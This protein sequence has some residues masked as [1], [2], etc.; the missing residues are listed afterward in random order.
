MLVG[1]IK[2]VNGVEQV[3]ASVRRGQCLGAFA[4]GGSTVIVLYPRGEIKLDDD[5]LRNSAEEN[6]ETLMRVGW[7]VGAKV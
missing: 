7:R 1:S 2:Y 5:L 4:Y 6:C 3:G